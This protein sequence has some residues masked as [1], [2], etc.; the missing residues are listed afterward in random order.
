[1]INPDNETR[2]SDNKESGSAHIRQHELLMFSVPTAA[3]I[4]R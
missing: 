2:T 4:G 3:R 1:V